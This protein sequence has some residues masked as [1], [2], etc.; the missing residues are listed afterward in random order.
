MTTLPEAGPVEAEADPADPADP[1]P[2]AVEVFGDRLDLATRYAVLLA[3]AGVERGLIGPREA[4][5]LW[6]RHLLNC[7]GLAE[8]LAPD[9][10]VMDLGSGAGLPGLVLAVVRP[11]LRLTLVEPLLRRATFLTEAVAELGLPNVTVHRGRAEEMGKKI[12]YDVVTAR[13]VAP[14]DKLIRWSLPLLTPGGRLLA[15]KGDRAESELAAARPGLRHA[16]VTEA[17]V[18]TVGTPERRTEAR[19]VVLTRGT[20]E[21]GRR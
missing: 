1:P 8:L 6:D 15:L 3:G 11:D 2:Y 21:R 9:E 7:A 19:V 4:P 14:L 13:A 10:S 17:E 12:A 18:V 5:R 20:R 16:G